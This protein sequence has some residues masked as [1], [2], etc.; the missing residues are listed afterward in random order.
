MSK[1]YYSA[2]G[3]VRGDC[4]HKHR[5]AYTAGK[6]VRDDSIGCQRQGGYTDRGVQRS[7]GED[8]NIL[9]GA[10]ADAGL[11]GKYKTKE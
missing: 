9:E 5:S 10:D 4:G 6:C 2:N 3:S 7:D 8:L 1:V 11:G